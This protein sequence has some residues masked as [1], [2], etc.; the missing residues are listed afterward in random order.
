M[1]V[2]RRARL[3]DRLHSVAIRVLRHAR[4]SDKQSGLGPARLSALSVLVYAGPCTLAQ[5]ADAEQVQPPTMTR[6]V[7]GL[8]KDGL[9]RR[10]TSQDDRR[11]V[12]LRATRKGEALLERARTRRLDR[13]Q[14]L[15][16]A[17]DAGDIALLDDALGRIFPS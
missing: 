6:I 4:E 5:L 14:A 12:I 10:D 13:I 9:V 2:N 15:L 1:A 3:A 16:A 7:Q 11:A 17:A 8:Q